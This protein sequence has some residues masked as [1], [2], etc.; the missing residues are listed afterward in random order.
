MKLKDIPGIEFFRCDGCDRR[1]TPANLSLVISIDS[2][3]GRELIIATCS[4]CADHLRDSALTVAAE[5]AARIK[6]T[7]RLRPGRLRAAA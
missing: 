4:K 1:F 5:L 2:G 3:D 6:R 7:A